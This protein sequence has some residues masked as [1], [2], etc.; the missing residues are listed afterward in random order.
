[1]EISEGLGRPSAVSEHSERTL[2]SKQLSEALISNPKEWSL[3]G[4]RLSNALVT[5]AKPNGTPNG[6]PNGSDHRPDLSVAELL[7]EEGEEEAQTFG[8]LVGRSSAMRRIFELTSKLANSNA[9]L[10]TDEDRGIGASHP[11]YY[12]VDLLY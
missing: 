12:S 4:E 7:G 8:S 10:P 5:E 9:T 6:S 11:L 2:L 3:P 1:M